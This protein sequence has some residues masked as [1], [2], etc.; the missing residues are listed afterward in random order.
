MVGGR[1]SHPMV[2]GKWSHGRREVIPNRNSCAYLC[3]KSLRFSIKG[4]IVV[5]QT[6]QNSLD[7]VTELKFLDTSFAVVLKLETDRHLGRTVPCLVRNC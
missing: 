1:W 7:D 5:F 3:L 6:A 4:M 2:G